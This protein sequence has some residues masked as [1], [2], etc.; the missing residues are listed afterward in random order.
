MPFLV[1]HWRFTAPIAAVVAL[2]VGVG[3]FVWY[4]TN[5]ME[6]SERISATPESWTSIAQ[7]DNPPKPPP[8]PTTPNTEAQAD[9]AEITP[10]ETAAG[11]GAADDLDPLEARFDDESVLDAQGDYTLSPE[12]R[13]KRLKFV[14]DYFDGLDRSFESID[15]NREA[16]SASMDELEESDDESVLDAE[17][18]TCRRSKNAK[19]A[20]K[21]L[22]ISL[23]N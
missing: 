17:T 11:A 7:I 2:C 3:G 20:S 10:L 14:K 22:M 5:Q 16:L 6:T 15:G 13:E 18:I 8:A 19:N 21:S 23:M 1:K 9:G 12:E 4:G